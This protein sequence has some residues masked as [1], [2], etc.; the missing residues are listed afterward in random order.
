MCV[1]VWLGAQFVPLIKLP[2]LASIPDNILGRPRRGELPFVGFSSEINL[3]FYID[4]IYLAS[5]LSNF[6]L[7]AMNAVNG[8]HG[9]LVL[10]R[11]GGYNI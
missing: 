1:G 4:G 6:S 11:K 5:I 2:R 3:S 8:C 7:P 10:E 9:L